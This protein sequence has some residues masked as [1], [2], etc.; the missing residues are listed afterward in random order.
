M[1]QTFNLKKFSFL[2]YGLGSTGISVVKFFKKKRINNFFVWDENKKLRKKFRFNCAKNIKKTLEEVDYIVLSPGISLKKKVNKHLK[3]LKKKIITDIDLLYLSNSKF[4]SIVVTGTNGKSTTC[5]IIFHLLKKNKFNAKLGGNIGTPVLDFKIKKNTFFVIEASSFQLS[6][7]QFIH[8]DF[9]IL[10]NITNDHLDWHGSQQDYLKS[11]F[12]IFDL[13]KKDNFALINKQYINIFQKR[14][15]LSKLVKLK[16]NEY[17]RIKSQIDNRYLRLNINDENMNFAFTLA[18]LLK[19]SKESFIKSMTSFVGL[20]HR[21]EIF[22]KKKNVIFIN[23]SKAT[24]F[25][26]SRFALENCKNIYWIVGGLQKKGDKINLRHIKNNVIKSYI[27][28]KNV[29]FFKRQLKKNKMVTIITKSLK[30]S[31]IEALKDIK[32]NRRLNNIVLLSPGAASFD[33][34][35]NFEN[36]GNEFKR[37]CKLYAKKII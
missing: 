26:A 1:Y 24:S 32:L 15:Y 21:F 2:V 31:I 13:Q 35:K 25:Q 22:Y 12:K 18:K 3:K 37:L 11:K 34:F 36:R 6:H 30:I 10:L 29:K 33:Q 16:F 9:A 17:K 8:P 4:K 5:K 27:I 20:P 7:S 28:G 23:D 19:I 14:K